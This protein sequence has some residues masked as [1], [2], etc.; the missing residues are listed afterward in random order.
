MQSTC[1]DTLTYIS[2]MSGKSTATV[3]AS[4]DDLE[5]IEKRAEALQAEIDKLAQEAG[6][7]EARRAVKLVRSGAK[8]DEE[9]TGLAFNTVSNQMRLDTDTAQQTA[10]EKHATEE[11]DYEKALDAAQK[12][13]AS[14]AELA[15]L[16]ADHN[17]KFDEIEKGLA[18]DKAR[19]QTAYLAS[20]NELFAGLASQNPELQN[21]LQDALSK[22][23]IQSALQ[24]AI[25]EGTTDKL[26]GNK[27]LMDRLGKAL[28]I[29][30][31]AAF[32]ESYKND[33]V[34]LQTAV[35]NYIAQLSEAVGKD[36][37]GLENS[38]MGSTMQ[39]LI[40][41][42]LLKGLNF[43]DAN[44][45]SKLALALGQAN[46]PQV[47]ADAAHQA[48]TN[49]GAGGVTASSAPPV[50]VP[51]DIVPKPSLADGAIEG[52][53]AEL[54]K[55]LAEGL[56][57]SGAGSGAG[58]G[59]SSAPVV[60]MPVT[61]AP[62]PVVEE[63]SGSKLVDAVASDISA[64]T[65][66]VTTAAESISKAAATAFAKEVPSARSAGIA[67][68]QGLIDGAN[69]KKQSLITT[70]EGLMVAAIQAAKRKA[71]IASPSK[72]F[73]G[74]GQNIADAFSLGVD[75]RRLASQK[76]VEQLVGAPKTASVVNNN[77]NA[78][79]I[80]ITFPG[81]VVRS[82]NDIRELERRTQRLAR[83]LQYGLGARP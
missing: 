8:V 42:G 79:P 72:V 61:V 83:D 5:T 59:E 50:E 65:S 78:A 31:P 9:T 22:L 4:L 48:Y 55:L 38:P 33:P 54:D 44:M 27:D 49:T 56:P 14:D 45:Q 57:G 53:N 23:D 43:D 47:I 34:G 62:D 1:N 25:D 60:K 3:K 24:K 16:K 11:A 58:A 10:K 71:G 2:E 73:R 19:I 80:N 29:D 77:H 18:A 30:D 21:K 7:P 76:T 17:A 70:F 74:I 51:M 52:M 64:S 12:R 32:L 68:V 20:L 81:A 40:S 41:D 6:T 63:G 15:K 36:T 39:G 13:G 66:S 67:M 26:S 28:G 75:D 35:S 46:L 82:D 37:E 69:S